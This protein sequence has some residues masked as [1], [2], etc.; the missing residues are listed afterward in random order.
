M[1]DNIARLMAAGSLA[2]TAINASVSIATYRR[3]R[4]AVTCKATL[5]RRIRQMEDRIVLG[6]PSIEVRCKNRGEAADV[7]TDAY[8]WVRNKKRS[9]RRIYPGVPILLE[10][11]SP[12]PGAVREPISCFP[13]ELAAFQKGLVLTLD[14]KGCMRDASELG[15]VER[16]VSLVLRSGRTVKTSWRKGDAQMFTCECPRCA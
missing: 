14:V 8:L 15:K 16:R 3:K 6:S 2:V 11:A 9:Q 7:I 5:G 10:P 13:V 4:P 1:P 12:I